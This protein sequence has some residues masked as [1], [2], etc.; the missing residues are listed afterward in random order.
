MITDNQ[1]LRREIIDNCLKMNAVGLNQGTSGN[2]SIR[3]DDG[4]LITPSGIPYESLE[5]DDI[6]YVDMSGHSEH[7][8]PPSSEWRFHRDIMRAKPEVGAIVHAH[9]TYCTTLAIRRMS[10][11]A[12][13]YMIAV[14]GGSKIRCAEYRT[15][16]TQ[17]LSDVV[18]QALDNRTCCLMAHHGMVAT[19]P[20]MAKAMWVA[21]ETE[22][23][24]RQYFYTLLLGVPNILPDDEIERVLEK[25]ETYGMNAGHYVTSPAS[26][27]CRD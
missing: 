6:V 17:E 23:L 4:F 7:R 27:V 5:T 10:I 8:L 2:L 12:V 16:G 25:F 24:A 15:Y 14:S 11:P 13:H 20:S 9:P 22:V 21:E 3:L 1:D 18:V 19:G 26:E